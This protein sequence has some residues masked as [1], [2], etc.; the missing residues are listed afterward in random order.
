MVEQC[1]YREYT[2]VLPCPGV[3]HR[4]QSQ[5]SAREPR[6]RYHNRMGKH[7]TADNVDGAVG[8]QAY[9]DAIIDATG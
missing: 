8:T 3:A 4:V 7:A 5:G 9:A 6:R 2:I 1:T